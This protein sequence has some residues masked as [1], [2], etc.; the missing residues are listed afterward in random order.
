M[1]IKIE[2]SIKGRV[3]ER[4]DTIN[5]SV[6]LPKQIFRIAFKHDAYANFSNYLRTYRVFVQVH[7]YIVLFYCTE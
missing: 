6:S 3:I 2:F 1:C 7:M 5:I 4:K